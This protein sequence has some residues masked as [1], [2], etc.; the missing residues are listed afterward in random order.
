MLKYL[1]ILIAI[2][3]LGVSPARADPYGWE[4]WE[5]SL[6]GGT[7]FAAT[8]AQEQRLSIREAG[9]TATLAQ[10]QWKPISE[11]ACVTGAK[12]L[13]WFHSPPNAA[14]DVEIFLKLTGK[15]ALEFLAA[16]GGTKY[17]VDKRIMYLVRT[18]EHP[19][20]VKAVIADGQG[21]ALQGS[22]ERSTGITETGIVAKSM[23][24][25]KVREVLKAIGVESGQGKPHRPRPT[26][27]AWPTGLI[28]I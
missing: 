19:S 27:A 6:V 12:L 25:A 3:L 17:A 9:L 21:C 20:V 15:Q 11:E 2:V 7:D 13:D 5:M 24:P 28:T 18:P 16:T 1:V 10:E 4:D 23:T 22:G 8:L 26:P 14:P